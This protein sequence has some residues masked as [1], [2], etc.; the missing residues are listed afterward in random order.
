MLYN[1]CLQQV[2]IL[3]QF[4]FKSSFYQNHNFSVKTR[5]CIHY[6]LIFYENVLF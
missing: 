4:N 1:I 2:D 6:E 3:T 5:V